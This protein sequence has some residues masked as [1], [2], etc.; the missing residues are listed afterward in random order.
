[1]ISRNRLALL[2]AGASILAACATAPR[3]AQVAPPPVLAEA[4]PA[5]AEPAPVPQLISQ[6]AIPHE[7]FKLANGLTVLVHTDRKAP[8]V[9]VAMW[10]NVGSKDEPKGRTGFAHLFEHLMFNGSENLPGDFFE[11]LQQIGATDYN[12]T[13]NFDRTNYFQ[14][15][16]T[17]A[18]ERALFMESDRMGYL[19]G[20]VTQTKLDN[21]RGVVQNEKRQG[22]NRPGGLVF[23]EVLKNLFPQGH[24]YHH[25]V[26]GSMADLDSASL[27][28][29][30]DWFRDNY[31]PNNA[32]LV[33]AG[34]V[35]APSARPLVEKYFGAIPRGPQNVPAEAAVPVLA[36]TESVVMK[37]RVATTT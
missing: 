31:G 17:G 2:L 4:P 5:P 16:P 27:A 3:V 6:V 11:Y 36:A 28:D 26:I 34:D 30:R 24:P 20:A 29:V 15:V 18:L 23:E 21:Q 10:Y 32:V 37:D 33:L 14:T 8:V 12:G 9:G 1:M 13:T 35:D 25:T 19:L 22:D 7:E